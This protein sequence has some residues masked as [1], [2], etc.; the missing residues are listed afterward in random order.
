MHLEPTEVPP[1]PPGAQWVSLDG[2]TDGRGGW[3]NHGKSAGSLAR[4]LPLVLARA[5]PCVLGE[6]TIMAV[7]LRGGA[8]AWPSDP[9]TACSWFSPTQG[10]GEEAACPL[11]G[12]QCRQRGGSVTQNNAGSHGSTPPGTAPC[13]PARPHGS[14]LLSQGMHPQRPPLAPSST[15]DSTAGGPDALVRAASLACEAWPERPPFLTPRLMLRGSGQLA[16][17]TR[18]PGAGWALKPRL[19]LDLGSWPRGWMAGLGPLTLPHPKATNS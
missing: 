10:L 5:Q 3:R 4:P 17:G 11:R 2:R 12:G 18:P 9:A 6:G 14:C 13:L 15:S 19:L 8:A 7:E 16:K 1:G